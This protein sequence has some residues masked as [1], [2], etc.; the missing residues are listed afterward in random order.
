MSDLSGHIAP[1]TVEK[2]FTLVEEAYTQ[3]WKGYMWQQRIFGSAI[4]LPGSKVLTGSTQAMLA[5]QIGLQL[6]GCTAQPHD[7]V[8][9]VGLS[10]SWLG[11]IYYR[12]QRDSSC[13]RESGWLSSLMLFGWTLN[14]LNKIDLLSGTF[15]RYFPYI[16][17]VSCYAQVAP[18]PSV[19]V[20][21]CFPFGFHVPE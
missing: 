3:I 14:G 19:F 4:L 12:L 7:Q 2:T 11:L 15:E 9:S 5:P 13:F 16:A 1:P 21:T 18:L 6:P 20:F 8:S 17:F 10:S